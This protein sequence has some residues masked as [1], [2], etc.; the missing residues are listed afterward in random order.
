MLRKLRC[1]AKQMDK[2]M[3]TKKIIISGGG[4]GGHI[5]PAIAI[6]DTIKHKYPNAEILFVGAE[7][8][9]EMEKVPKAGYEI[10]GLPIR[11]IQRKLTLKN[12]AVPFKLIASLLKAKRIVK[13]MK[14]DIA[15]GVGGYASAATLRVASGQKV[16]TLIQE[17]NSYPGITN[18]WLA[19]RAKVICVA[20]ENLERFFPKEKIVVTGNPVRNEMVQIEGKRAEA[21]SFFNLD[22]AKKTILV[23]GGSLGART[24][25]SSIK[26]D[27]Q[28]LINA[29]VQVI[30]QCGKMY[31]NSLRNDLGELANSD[32]VHLSDFIF[33][34]DLA[35]AAADL[36]ISRA[37]AISV[38]EVCLVGKPV[39]LVPSPNVSED[40]QTK[41]AMALVSK[42]AAVLVKDID[43]VEQLVDKALSTLKDE[44]KCAQLS[45]EIK[46]LAIADAADRILVEIEKLWGK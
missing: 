40:H 18:K 33:K 7:G 8:K 16:P 43:A 23:I 1:Q 27:L 2:P 12:L 13:Q 35:Y 32:L 5:F 4:T 44:V 38:S 46:K 24:L 22:P 30:W 36:I 9:M 6:A 45:T 42:N 17:Q 10:V 21:F 28:K 19:K 20:Y 31:L 34:M 14:P 41:N 37:G 26:K 25:N 39:I 3:E 11:G 29:D 15:I